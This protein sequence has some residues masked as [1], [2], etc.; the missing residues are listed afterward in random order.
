MPPGDL[1]QGR[2]GL[3]L[4]GQPVVLQLDE[5]IAAAEDVLQPAGQRLGLA[6]VVGQQGLEH[7]PAQAAGGG[8]EAVVVPLEQLP[9]EAGL[10]VIAL[11]VGRRGQLEQVP[12]ALG[13]LGQQRQV[14]VELL[15]PVDV[16]AGVVDP[17]PAHRALVRDSAAM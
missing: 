10:V 5:E 3:V 8:D 16:A 15:A 13:G 9:V 7:H 1:H 4:L 11:E 14:V 2:V 6:P 17:A 12:V